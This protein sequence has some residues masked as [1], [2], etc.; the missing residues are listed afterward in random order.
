MNMKGIF[1]SINNKFRTVLCCTGPNS[2]GAK[3]LFMPSIRL[4][5]RQNIIF[6]E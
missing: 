4:S 2:C 3:T 5:G 1:Q 6:G